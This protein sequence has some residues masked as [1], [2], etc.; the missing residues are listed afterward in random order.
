MKTK[1]V[2]YKL[3]LFGNGFI[4][5]PNIINGGEI[6]E[7]AYNPAD[8]I[9]VGEIDS[10]LVKK[11]LPESIIKVISKAEYKKH[12]KELSAKKL[13]AYKKKLFE[14]HTD[15]HFIK[16]AREKIEGNNQSWKDYIKRVNCIKKISSLDDEL[17][18]FNDSLN[19]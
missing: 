13:N 9:F 4:N 16:A 6:W 7:N 2:L 11:E 8:T 1:T 14:I 18:D 19:D 15:P 5:P 12:F 17:K 3:Q 10:E